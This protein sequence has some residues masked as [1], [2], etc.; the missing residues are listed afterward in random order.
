MSLLTLLLKPAGP[1][2]EGYI[3]SRRVFAN[4][5]RHMLVGQTALLRRHPTRPG[6]VLAQFDD[7]SL[8]RQWTHRWTEWEDDDWRVEADSADWTGRGQ[9]W[10]ESYFQVFHKWIGF[11]SF[12]FSCLYNARTIEFG[13][14][15]RINPPPEEFR[16]KFRF[17]KVLMT[18]R[19]FE[20]GVS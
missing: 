17:C 9:E 12:G 8:G 15:P 4:E 20:D 10:F 6:K 14:W 7:L 5:S 3:T 16:F 18:R 13:F 2:R 11:F 19:E 1:P